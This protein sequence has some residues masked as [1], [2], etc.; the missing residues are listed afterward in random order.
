MIGTGR[1]EERRPFAGVV[2]LAFML[3]L[4]VPC[5]ALASGGGSSPQLPPAAERLFQEA[6]RQFVL[7]HFSAAADALRSA[8]EAAGG[9]C[10]PCVKVLAYV[11][12]GHMGEA[13]E[14][15]RKAITLLAGDSGQAGA[16]HQLGDL[17]LAQSASPEAAA[18]AEQA[19]QHE[20]DMAPAFRAEGLAGIAHARMQ[21]KRYREAAAAA[22]RLLQV[23]PDGPLAGN[24]RSTIC[25]A[26]SGG[27][28]SAA[29]APM[30]P[31]TSAVPWG[32]PP[33]LP[34]AD[35]E[36]L[37]VG[38]DVTK[39]IKVGGPPPVYTE[40]ARKARLQG[41]VILEAIIDRDGCI[42]NAQILKG[43]PMG[44]DQSALDA[45]KQ[46]AFAPATLYGHPV[47]VFYTLTVNFTVELPPDPK[48]GEAHGNAGP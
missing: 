40:M 3:A 44:L 7:K 18:E 10:L 21:G 6:Q 17:L 30:P 36:P 20:V 45:M 16:F 23:V 42:S 48:Q 12:S 19:Y 43:M 47:K 39:P 24:A 14:A 29:D 22:L 15:T 13:I 34:P 33:G 11:P 37:R 1:G 27:G 46:W 31:V 28:L 8:N 2:M 35:T 41:V 38:G 5:W 9:T 26:R 32:A 25:A 4:A